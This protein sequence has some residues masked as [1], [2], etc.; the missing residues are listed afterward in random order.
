M[1]AFSF[2][3]CKAGDSING[4]ALLCYFLKIFDGLCVGPA[5]HEGVNHFQQRTE[6]N[7]AF[8]P[9]SFKT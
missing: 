2:I 3:A 7:N 4:V 1:F 9:R 5:K 8:S 6:G